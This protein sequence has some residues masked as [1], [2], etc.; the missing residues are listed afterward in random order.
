[1]Q[2]LSELE[3]GVPVGSRGKCYG[4]IGFYPLVVSPHRHQCASR[5]ALVV[6]RLRLQPRRLVEARDR[7]A[8]ASSGH[9]EP[10]QRE[11]KFRDRWLERDGALSQSDGG[12]NVP[13]L[14]RKAA[15][16]VVRSR[17]GRIQLQDA[18]V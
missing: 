15:Q 2:R 10:A 7:L 11:V 17:T 12:S 4:P 16:H 14:R 1:M 5:R 9:V 8:D 3:I 18:L 6:Q 13:F